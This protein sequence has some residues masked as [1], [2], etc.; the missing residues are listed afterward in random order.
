MKKTKRRLLSFAIILSLVFGM[1]GTINLDSTH[2]ATKKIHLKKTTISLSIGKT[3]QQ[4]LINK[5]GK[6]IKAT[7]VKWKSK[8]T[9]VAKIS[10]KGK[11]SAI[12]VG[13]ASM[14]AKYKGKTYKFK[15]NVKVPPNPADAVY[16][17]VKNNGYSVNSDYLIPGNRCIES[18]VYEGSNYTEIY[19]ISVNTS[20][21]NKI[22][23]GSFRVKPAP[24]KYSDT[25][26]T[27][28]ME[29]KTDDTKCPVTFWQT[30]YTT[31]S[32]SS[33]SHYTSRGVITYANYIG[34]S[35]YVNETGI[36]DITV[37]DNHNPVSVGSYDS[38]SL[39]DGVRGMTTGVDRLLNQCFGL[40]LR[41]LG[42]TNL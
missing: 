38:K 7:S 5:N 26:E 25:T 3:Y 18:E 11:V 1:V 12:K 20:I 15:V 16:N 34:A 14:T 21:S 29:Y 4:K 23:F 35:Y 6:T 22:Y 24:G 33:W 36:T 31:S 10:K 2:A 8:N 32:S 19:V 39:I 41:N 9:S 17:Y 42:F 27:T 40:R 28:V 13:T 30:Y 37:G